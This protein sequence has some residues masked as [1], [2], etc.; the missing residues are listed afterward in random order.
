MWRDKIIHGLI[1][2]STF[3][4]T[5]V[6]GHHP[7]PEQYIYLL[8]TNHAPPLPVLTYHPT[9]SKKQIC[10]GVLKLLWIN[11]CTEEAR[12]RMWMHKL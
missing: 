9:T 6:Y 12:A 3:S 11:E 5:A 4:L 1:V 8:N 2:D 10:L 7:L